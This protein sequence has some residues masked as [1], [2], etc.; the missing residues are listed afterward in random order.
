[1]LSYRLTILCTCCIPICLK[2]S[3]SIIVLT[4]LATEPLTVAKAE[5]ML[6]HIDGKAVAELSL[7]KFMRF[8]ETFCTHFLDNLEHFWSRMI[9]NCRDVMEAS[10]DIAIA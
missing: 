2:K 7:H 5:D 4:K 3:L 10:Y 6:E 9:R 8:I 1:M